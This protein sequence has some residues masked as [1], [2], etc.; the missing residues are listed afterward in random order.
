MREIQLLSTV[1]LSAVVGGLEDGSGG[2]K[3]ETEFRVNIPIWGTP[4]QYRRV[5]EEPNAYLRCLDLMSRQ[6]GLFSGPTTVTQRQ[7]KFCLP[8][9]AHA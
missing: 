9:L 4:I 5:V 6:G 7:E 1:E 2:A 8:M 3:R